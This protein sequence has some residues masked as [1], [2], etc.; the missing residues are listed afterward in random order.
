M[1]LAEQSNDVHAAKLKELHNWSVHNVYDVVPD[2]GQ[3]FMT[4]RWVITTKDTPIE[5]TVKAQ[6]VAHGFQEAQSFQTDSPTCS[7]E[8]I[9]LTLAIIASMSWRLMSLDIKTAFLQGQNI[10]HT[11]YIKPPP[12]ANTNMLWQ[13][14]KCIYGLAD[15]PR[16]FYLRLREVLY[17]SGASVSQLD[18]ALFFAHDKNG[19]LIGVIACHVDDLLYGGTSQFHHEVINNLCDKL[20]FG[21]KNS[22]AFTYI[23]MHVQQHQNHTIS[24]DQHSFTD[25]IAPISIPKPILLQTNRAS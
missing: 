15:A 20:E 25:S 21:S 4:V 9:R 16:C 19:H 13:L 22:S 7:K 2:N 8:S 1:L 11:V 23:G 10:N 18:E 3:A 14:N 5:P 6:L 24:L 12:E 17:E